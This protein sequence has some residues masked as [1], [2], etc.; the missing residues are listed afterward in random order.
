MH[1]DTRT[2]TNPTHLHT[3]THKHKINVKKKRHL[4]RKTNSPPVSC[5]PLWE[6]TETEEGVA[7]ISEL[8]PTWTEAMVDLR[9]LHL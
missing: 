4:Q 2:Y 1:C 3:H 5:E 8:E 6:I 7:G 9:L